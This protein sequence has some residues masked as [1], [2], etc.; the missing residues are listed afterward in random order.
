MSKFDENYKRAL[1][2]SAS[3]GPLSKSQRDTLERRVSEVL[4]RSNPP[5]PQKMLIGMVREQ[6]E[7]EG[8]IGKGSKDS[9]S[10]RALIRQCLIKVL[11]MVAPDDVLDALL[12]TLV[13]DHVDKFGK[14][15]PFEW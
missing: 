15:Y 1:E 6:A 14:P 9:M 5:I 2:S 8:I 12:T 13:Q 3:I 11:M 10:D 4:T 7:Q